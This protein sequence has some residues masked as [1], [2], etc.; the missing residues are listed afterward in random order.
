MRPVTKIAINVETNVTEKT[1]AETGARIT[2]SVIGSNI[3]PSTQVGNG[4]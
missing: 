1:N 3:L 2:V 4:T